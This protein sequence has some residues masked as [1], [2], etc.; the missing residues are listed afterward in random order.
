MGTTPISFNGSSTYAADLQQNITHAVAIASIPLNQLNANVTALQG[1][2]TEVGYLQNGFVMLQNAIKSLA[3][4]A[5]GG[6]LSA[7]VS[8]DTVATENLNSG[9]AVTPGT[10][11]LNVINAGSPT[12]SVSNTG[13]PTVA[14]PV[15]GIDQH[16]RLV[17]ALRQRFKLYHQSHHEFAECAGAGD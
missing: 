3:A 11:A 13:L 17:H 16:V 14:D 15:G 8:D 12:T 1:Q 2:S 5:N 10:Y 4:G 9:S 6:G 7:T